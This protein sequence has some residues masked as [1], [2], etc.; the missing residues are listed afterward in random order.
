MF[1]AISLY[2]QE[3]SRVQ[4]VAYGPINLWSPLADMMLTAFSADLHDTIVAVDSDIHQIRRFCKK[5]Q[6]IGWIGEKPAG[7]VYA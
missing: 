2:V 5:T 4:G 7:T 1:A 6:A 3:F